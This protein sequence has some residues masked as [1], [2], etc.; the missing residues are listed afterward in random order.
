MKWEYINEIKS[1]NGNFN[2]V[3]H[4]T[5]SVVSLIFNDSEGVQELWLNYNE[6]NELCRLIQDLSNKETEQ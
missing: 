4:R 2:F 3:H 6:W 1:D 5:A